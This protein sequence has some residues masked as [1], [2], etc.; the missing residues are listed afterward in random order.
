MFSAVPLQLSGTSTNQNDNFCGNPH[1][2]CL[3]KM[4]R[5]IK[6]DFSKEAGTKIVEEIDGVTNEIK[7]ASINT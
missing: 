5:P 3:A 2:P 6:C 7:T 1:P 4:C